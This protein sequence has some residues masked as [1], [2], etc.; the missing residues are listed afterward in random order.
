M[1]L[2]ATRHA[3]GTAVL[4]CTAVLAAG[5]ASASPNSPA[6]A[7]SQPAAGSSVPSTAASTPAP[8]PA[9]ATSQCRSSALH[10][11]VD[12][13]QSGAAA[14]SVYY[15]INFTNVSSRQCTLYGYPGVSFVTGESGS[16]LGRAATRDAAARPTAVT[17]DPGQVA[18]ATLQVASAGNFDPSACRPVTAH[19][20]R[21]FPPDQFTPIY[22]RFTALACSSRLPSGVGGQ[23]GIYAVR[24]GPG[25]AG[26][27]P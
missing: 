1:T 7:A 6:P 12:I 24:P 16:Q 13:T 3:V 21:I 2:S 25:M 17:L 9:A 15:P 26:A 5:C 8:S 23:L 27:A 14:G 20:L 11:K 10:A 18:H 4:L 19:W 22:A